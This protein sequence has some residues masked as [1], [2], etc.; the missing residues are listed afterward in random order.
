[1]TQCNE[2]TVDE[3]KSKIPSYMEVGVNGQDSI[4]EFDANFQSVATLFS[5]ARFGNAE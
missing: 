4:E 3:L 5:A 2:I 1:M